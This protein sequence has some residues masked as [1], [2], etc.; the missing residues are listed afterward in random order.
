M[1]PVIAPALLG[2][3]LA[4][5]AMSSSCDLG[6][7]P[8]V[9]D[10]RPDGLSA[11]S[12][13]IEAS[14]FSSLQM[15]S[16]YVA[17][18]AL[19]HVLGYRNVSIDYTVDAPRAPAR[20]AGCGDRCCPL[21]TGAADADPDNLC[22]AA[23]GAARPASHIAAFAMLGRSSRAASVLAEVGAGLDAAIAGRYRCAR[24]RSQRQ[25]A[26][27]HREASAVLPATSMYQA[28]ANWATTT[29]PTCPRGP[30]GRS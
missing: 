30:T 16:A 22:D 10:F 27:C 3:L 15:V 19:E 18:H 1:G 21:F 23:D 11:S 28:R 4:V 17:K 7:V 26:R 5:P 25:P 2:L 14:S 29:S 8:V 6:P 24:C 12:L 20:I 13:V 9:R